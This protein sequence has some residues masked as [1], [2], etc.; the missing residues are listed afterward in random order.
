MMSFGVMAFVLGLNGLDLLKQAGIFLIPLRLVEMQSQ[1]ELFSIRS[2]V[3]FMVA[4]MQKSQ[5]QNSLRI[6]G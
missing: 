5:H 6:A 2:G 1:N 3:Q 4:L